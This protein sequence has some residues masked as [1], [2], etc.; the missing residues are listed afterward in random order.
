[1]RALGAA[2]LLVPCLAHGQ[3]AGRVMASGSPVAGARVELWSA[4]TRLADRISD[5][6]GRF[7]FASP[8]GAGALALLAR[9][10]G[11]APLRRSITALTRDVT[12]ELTALANTLPAVTITAALQCP[13][14][15]D[16]SARARWEA[17]RRR[18]ADGSGYARSS[19][20]EMW[21]GV[22]T[23]DSVGEVERARVVRGSRGTTATGIAMDQLLI[24][25][26]GYAWPTDEV[27]ASED[28]GVWQ[29]PLLDADY[30]QHF[31]EPGFG[32]RHTLSERPAADGETVL[33]FCP[34]D[35]RRPG[36]EGTLRI[37][38]DGSPVSARWVFANPATGAEEA[39]GEVSFAPPE[40]ADPHPILLAASGL[41]WRRLRSGAYYERWM[42][43]DGWTVQPGDSL[44]MTR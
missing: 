25:R 32:E 6:S 2:A 39:G 33:V 14:V 19:E 42:R 10:V 40:P 38:R 20:A 35:R 5:D 29:Y 9:R 7:Q 34:R 27:G 18:Y 13:N 37:A 31:I 22:T 26:Y 44:L 1:M 15:P 8:A 28:Y 41:F 24:V 4:T 17:L 3:I 23:R 12:L 11:F 43:Y 16:D 21:R 30:A 36:L